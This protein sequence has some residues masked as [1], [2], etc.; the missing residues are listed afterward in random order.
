MKQ[1]KE[2]KIQCDALTILAHLQDCK[3]EEA[4]PVTL[5]LTRTLV[6]EIDPERDIGTFTVALA[7]KALLTEL[8]STLD[9]LFAEID[10]LHDHIEELEIQLSRIRRQK[11]NS[12]RNGN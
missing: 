6:S 1:N 12:G 5:E 11:Q 8:S 9:S 4:L 2:D 7:A 10:E 3:L